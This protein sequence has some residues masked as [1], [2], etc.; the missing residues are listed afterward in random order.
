MDPNDF[1]VPSVRS[2]ETDEEENFK[3][4]VLLALNELADFHERVKK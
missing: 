1:A 2:A 4:D 3:R